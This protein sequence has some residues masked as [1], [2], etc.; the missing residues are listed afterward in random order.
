MTQPRKTS[1]S[2]PATT[3]MRS[4]EIR[5]R[6]IMLQKIIIGLWRCL[7]G[8]YLLERLPVHRPSLRNYH[9]S[10]L[11]SEIHSVPVTTFIQTLLATLRRRLMKWALVLDCWYIVLSDN[12]RL[13]N[14][15]QYSKPERLKNYQ[16]LKRARTCCTLDDVKFCCCNFIWNVKSC[17]LMRHKQ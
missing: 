13:Q 5:R 4:G 16:W 6:F 12:T 17:S 10:Y 3:R 15:M 14:T 2:A 9:F 1:V 8:C 7:L 11:D